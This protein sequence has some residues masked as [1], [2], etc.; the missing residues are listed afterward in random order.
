[1]H[2]VKEGS[3]KRGR[4]A[5]DSNV[6]S[7]PAISPSVS[8]HGANR[9]RCRGGV[10]DEEEDRLYFPNCLLEVDLFCWKGPNFFAVE[11]Q[12]FL[13]ACCDF[14]DETTKNANLNVY[15]LPVAYCTRGSPVAD[16][17][18]FQGLVFLIFLFYVFF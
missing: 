7:H 12:P 9:V 4:R 15:M 10:E 18:K 11:V 5:C 3:A 17:K 2:R 1:M 14:L 13:H 8:R 16:I 6:L